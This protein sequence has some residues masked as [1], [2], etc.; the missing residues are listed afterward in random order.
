[1]GGRPHAPAERHDDH[2]Q[3]DARGCRRQAACR[4]R[5]S[6]REPRSRPDTDFDDAQRVPVEKQTKLR[7]RIAGRVV[8]GQN[9]DRP[10]SER[11]ESRRRIGD[12]PARQRR[13]QFASALITRGLAWLRRRGDSASRS[14][15][16]RAGRAG[17]AALDVVGAVLAVAV[18]ADG[19]VV[20]QARGISKAGT[21]RAADA[22]ALGEP[23]PAHAEP[24]QTPPSHR[25]IRRRRR[26]YR[27]RAGGRGPRRRRPPGSRL[28][29]A[30][31]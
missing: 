19:R 27:G 20:P 30:P 23:Q 9:P 22:E 12:A 10:R 21:H 4:Q 28:R 15:Y 1:M 16:R 3:H 29:C 17:A 7:L 5:R 8:L 24:R 31:G 18:D 11:A 14:R 6:P 13:E 26:E 25:S 2:R